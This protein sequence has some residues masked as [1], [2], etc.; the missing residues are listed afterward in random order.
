M[1]K[2]QFESMLITL[3]KVQKKST[4]H[5]LK[6]GLLSFITYCGSSNFEIVRTQKQAFIFSLKI[7][8]LKYNNVGISLFIIIGLNSMM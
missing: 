5:F 8:Y 7:K 1:C 4:D 6:N 3:S 2:I